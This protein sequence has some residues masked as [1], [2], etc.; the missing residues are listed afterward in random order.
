M[1][2][3]VSELLTMFTDPKLRKLLGVATL[4]MAA[5]VTVLAFAMTG[6]AFATD[7]WR[8]ISVN[9]AYLQ[10]LMVKEGGKDLTE[11]NKEDLAQDFRYFDRVEG[12][13]RV[14]FPMV[15]KPLRV[16]DDIYLS[17]MQEWCANLDYYFKLLETGSLAV[18]GKMTYHGQVWVHLARATVGAYIGYFA[19]AG[20]ASVLGLVG[21]WRTSSNQMAWTG[22]LMLFA[23]FFGVG[24]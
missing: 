10:R 1:V 17:P 19:V 2:K 4:C 23:F 6:V 15:E 5:I 11:K 7:N 24:Q 21:C 16:N 22:G 8:H 3:T 12:I 18:P 13:F 20:I 14:C 9:R